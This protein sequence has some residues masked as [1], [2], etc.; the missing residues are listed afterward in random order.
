MRELIQLVK[1]DCLLIIREPSNLIMILLL[2][3]LIATIFGAINNDNAEQSRQIS[4]AIVDLDKSKESTNYLNSLIAHEELNA[5]AVSLEQAREGTRLGEYVAFLLLEEGFGVG[6]RNFPLINSPSVMRI[7]AD[8]RK[9]AVSGLLT[10]ITIPLAMKMID[11]RLKASSGGT[12]FTNVQPLKIVTENFESS[13]TQLPLNAFSITVPQAVLWS[14]LACVAIMSAG[15]ANER[16]QH[17]ILRLKVS[18]ASMWIVL[19]SKLISCILTILVATTG[20]LMFGKFVFGI[21]IQ[22]FLLLSFAVVCS[23]FCFAGLMLAIGSIGRSPGA[24]AG[25]AWSIMVLFAMLGGG[26]MP[27][28][29]MPEWLATLSGVSPGKWSILLME[30]AIWRQFSVEEA[31]VPALIL[32]SLGFVGSVLGM[33]NLR[34]EKYQ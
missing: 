23:A 22:S 24:V 31:I 33:Y 12:P 27:Q 19:S 13:G 2:P 21:S 29:L 20:L 16:L 28:F 10:G 9:K 6:L 25:A 30:G 4:I 1:K 3:L 11:D 8:P 15:L 7:V 26:M 32:I 34:N 17:T 14:I 5:R 18:P